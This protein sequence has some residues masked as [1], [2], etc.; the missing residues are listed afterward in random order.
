M[1]GGN[2]AAAAAASKLLMEMGKHV[3]YCG[4]HGSGLLAKMCNNLVL[5]ASMAAV[6]E[7]LAL[8][9]RLGL[10]PKVLTEVSTGHL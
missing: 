5:S 4:D 7:S 2:K 1:V 8:G 3:I 6:A 9:N 10:D